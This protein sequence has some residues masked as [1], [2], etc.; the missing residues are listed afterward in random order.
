MQPDIYIKKNNLYRSIVPIDVLS[1]NKSP[2]VF[3][4]E[5]SKK[6]VSLMQ[7]SINKPCQLNQSDIKTVP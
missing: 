7:V 3:P 1:A 4:P 6:E 2:V 5:I